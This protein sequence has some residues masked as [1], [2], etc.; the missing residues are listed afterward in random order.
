MSTS[1]FPRHM[2]ECP[3]RVTHAVTPSQTDARSDRYEE[4][5]AFRARDWQTSSAPVRSLGFL[6]G[7]I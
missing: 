4:Q 7:T 2:P 5:C 6:G 3:Q 1:S